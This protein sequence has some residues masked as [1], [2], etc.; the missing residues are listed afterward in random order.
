[1]LY[2]KYSNFN[3]KLQASARRAEIKHLT[4]L[5]MCKN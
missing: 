3:D 5:Q 4:G 2:I 1:M